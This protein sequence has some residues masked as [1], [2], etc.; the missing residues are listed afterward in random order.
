MTLFIYTHS[1]ALAS[2]QGPGIFFVPHL[3]PEYRSCH[4]KKE[5]FSRFW[6]VNMYT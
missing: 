5:P 6:G 1:P 3:V 4:N 2:P